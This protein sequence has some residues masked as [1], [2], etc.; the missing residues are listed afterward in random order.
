M[1]ITADE[2]IGDDF[3]LLTG[4]TDAYYRQHLRG[5]E[6]LAAGRWLSG[7]P[8]EERPGLRQIPGD[9]A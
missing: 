5:P 2:E 4:A 7:Q 9:D 3:A 8:L 1:V 6:H